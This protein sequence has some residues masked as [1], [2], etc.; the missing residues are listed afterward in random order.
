[1]LIL[2]FV[3]SGIGWRHN[4]YNPIQFYSSAGVLD[5]N[6]MKVWCDSL[7][8]STAAGQS[9]N[10]SSAGFT[11]I[12]TVQVIALQN[13]ATADTSPQVSIKGISNTAITVNITQANTNLV[14][15]LGLGLFLQGNGLVFSTNL[16]NIKL[17]VMVLGR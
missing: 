16:S 3:L 12:T 8:P 10:I 11:S 14:S 6:G 5:P 4:A 15:V 9:I 1:M 13:T 7:T 17:Y 2:A